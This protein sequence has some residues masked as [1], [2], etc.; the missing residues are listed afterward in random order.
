M[1]QTVLFITILGMAAVTYLPRVLPFWV[2]SSRR[3]PTAMVT[4][5]RYVPV[6]ALSAMLVPL[7][8]L[9]GDEIRLGLDNAFLWAAV[10]VALV[11]WRT[12]SFLASVVVGMVIV[13][14]SRCAMRP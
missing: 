3:L 6:A 13:A 2:L 7:L 8:L 5:L 11:A 4:W 10:P 12:R 9:E 14:A 1:D